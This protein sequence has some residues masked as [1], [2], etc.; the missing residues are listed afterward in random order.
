MKKKLPISTDQLT[1]LL[2]SDRG[3]FMTAAS[4][5]TA[6]R[7]QARVVENTAAGLES[8]RQDPPD[9][10]L[11]DPQWS[12]PTADELFQVLATS[13][14]TR[15][16]PVLLM[17]S[18]GRLRDIISALINIAGKNKDSA[19]E[20]RP[21]P[22]DTEE[23]LE[24]LLAERTAELEASKQ[25]LREQLTEHRRIE[26][27]LRESER[28][29]LELF[30]N[31]PS[32]I[33]LLGVTADQGFKCIDV[34]AA[35][36]QVF[37][38]TR[39]G[40]QCRDNGIA[41]STDVRGLLM[42]I[43]RRCLE[44]ER[45][46]ED[47]LEIEMLPGRRFFD[48]TVVP[49]FEP[50]GR[51]YRLLCIA[52]DITDRRRSELF[53]KTRLAVFEQLVC[54]A[55]LQDL[56]GMI[57]RYVEEC[58]TG[59]RGCIRWNFDSDSFV[60]VVAAGL[61]ADVVAP[62]C[63]PESAADFIVCPAGDKGIT[64]DQ[65]RRPHGLQCQKHGPGGGVLSCW[66]EPI[67]DPEGRRLGVFCIHQ[68]EAIWPSADDR[69]LIHQASLLAAKVIE[70]K[71]ADE[72]L[73]V[74]EHDFR[75]LAENLPDN[76][77]RYDPQCRATYV[78]PRMLELFWRGKVRVVLGMTPTEAH[79]NGGAAIA[80]YEAKLRGVLATGEP[81]EMDI[82]VKGEDDRPRI[83]HILFVAELDA[84]ENVFG[85]LAIGRD[86]SEHRQ[87]VELL[88]A[89]EQEFRTLAENSP[90]IIVRYD[91]NG[92]RL[93]RNPA[94]QKITGVPGEPSSLPSQETYWRASLP[95]VQYQDHLLR[96]IA[97]GTPSQFMMAWRDFDGRWRD[98]AIH[99]LAERNA[100]GIVIGA[101]VV[102]RELTD[103]RKTELQLE[104]SEAMLRQLIARQE[105]ARE[106][107]RKRIA[108]ELHDEM[109]QFLSALRL[110]IS[111]LRMHGGESDPLLA[112]TLQRMTD[113]VDGTI[114]VVRGVV[115]DL[116]PAAL[117]MGLLPALEWLAEEF[118]K[119]TRIECSLRL[120]ELAQEFNE[121]RTIVIFRIV[122]ES[123]TNI[124]RHAAASKALVSLKRKSDRL[125][126]TI[127]DNGKGFD[128]SC[129]K[130]HSFGLI[131]IEERV[132]MLGG[133]LTIRSAADCGTRLLISL[134]TQGLG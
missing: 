14:D 52:R 8:A 57:K 50:T 112:Q 90:D 3:D 48:V 91:L 77:I 89:R 72:R 88:Q 117:D 66:S 5:L 20:R 131:G 105:C 46:V 110:D 109:G 1:I 49:L 120:D 65:H 24:T 95:F 37:Q 35:F 79:P 96:T 100:D 93:Y 63:R 27:L 51:V 69:E 103:L 68:H 84:R 99:M 32:P 134:P 107:E 70:C 26:A 130:E 113:L 4:E 71:Q 33:L 116:R 75:T 38:V 108:R 80:E 127:A 98:F 23:L 62:L 122:Q 28:H 31:T 44:A 9:L 64:E 85:A 123:L 124:S 83:H 125:I 2:F 18:P 73:R 22:P 21:Q 94:H 81:D 126:L 129:R 74:S 25:Q 76:I 59:Y 13:A 47:E 53:E 58:R 92:Q 115:S 86:V 102:G 10:I 133:E 119:R 43:C 6:H 121:E 36:E 12:G 30:D 87:M 55:P 19:R 67:L 114:K 54:G 104:K 106:N 82:M 101:L 11:L 17:S 7:V 29:Y 15:D 118:I 97:S 16:I 42:D 132:I 111:V 34:N 45:T 60:G 78:N 128:S 39:Q 56:L 61:P 40:G 41:M